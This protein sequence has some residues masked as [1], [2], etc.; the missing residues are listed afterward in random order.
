VTVFKLDAVK[1]EADTE[2]FEFEFDGDIYTMPPDFD[3]RAAQAFADADFQGALEILLGPD[4]WD[5]L[6]RSPKLLS[7]Q[8]INE[9]VGEW[10]DHIGV[11]VGESSAPSRS[12]R[13]AAA[14][15]KPTS[16]GSTGSTSRTSSKTRR[17]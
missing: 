12:L 2:P 4:Q 14:R 16:N 6:Y 10:C 15:S 9:M 8:R 13:R 3:A 5:R 1:R 7:L 17:G 11:E